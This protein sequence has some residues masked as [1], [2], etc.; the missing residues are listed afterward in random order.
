MHIHKFKHI[1]LTLGLVKRGVLARRGC[2]KCG[3]TFIKKYIYRNI[4]GGLKW[5][6]TR[7]LPLEEAEAACGVIKNNT[8]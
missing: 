7:Q 6:E 1:P 2:V 8:N 3:R 5:V 4:F